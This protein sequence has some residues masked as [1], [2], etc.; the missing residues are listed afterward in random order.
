MEGIGPES[1][2]LRSKNA[3][4]APKSRRY[5][6]TVKECRVDETGVLRSIVTIRLEQ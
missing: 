3:P 5:Q 2:P 1:T 4:K 6:G